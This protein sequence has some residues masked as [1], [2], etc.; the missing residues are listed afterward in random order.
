VRRVVPHRATTADIDIIVAIDVVVV[1]AIVTVVIEARAAQP[2]QQRRCRP[3]RRL[4]LMSAP[5]RNTTTQAQIQ[6]RNRNQIKVDQIPTLTLVANRMPPACLTT[7]TSA[8][9]LNLAVNPA[10]RCHLK[11][12]LIDTIAVVG[13]GRVV[14]DV[15][16]HATITIVIEIDAID[17]VHARARDT[18]VRGTNSDRG[19]GIVTTVGARARSVVFDSATTKCDKSV[20]AHRRQLRPR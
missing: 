8:T 10:S 7:A 1:A 17:I 20:C 6:A 13:I 5:H 4:P 11:A 15:V 3:R 2:L 12:T 16:A 18:T 19:R 14:I 9:A